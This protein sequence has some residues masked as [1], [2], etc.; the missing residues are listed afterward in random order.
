VL[1]QEL[2]AMC[3]KIETCIMFSWQVIGTKYQANITLT[4]AMVKTQSSMWARIIYEKL[5]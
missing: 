3:R 5:V 4:F 1:S 2:K